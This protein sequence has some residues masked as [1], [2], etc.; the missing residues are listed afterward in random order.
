MDEL[1]KCP[2]CGGFAKVAYLHPDYLKNESERYF[3]YCINKDCGVHGRRG[4]FESEA[5]ENWNRRAKQ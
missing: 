3:V 4:E 5:I 1:K 2:F